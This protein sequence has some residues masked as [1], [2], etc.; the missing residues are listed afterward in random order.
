MAGDV[1]AVRTGSRSGQFGSGTFFVP[2]YAAESVLIFKMVF[3]RELYGPLRRL[4]F[5]AVS[6][7][8]YQEPFVQGRHRLRE[9]STCEDSPP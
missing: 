8:L 6:G 7:R 4:S 2:L 3:S 9:G 5:G 1:H